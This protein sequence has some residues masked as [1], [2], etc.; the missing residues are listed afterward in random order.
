MNWYILEPKNGRGYLLPG[1]CKAAATQFH[2][3]VKTL[4]KTIQKY[5]EGNV[6]LV[7][8]QPQHAIVP[9]GHPVSQLT[10]DAT[11][12]LY[13]VAQRHIDDQIRC[14]DRRLRR[15]MTNLGFNFCLSTIQRWRKEL[16]GKYKS[17]Y[18]KPS[19]SAEQKEAR[20]DFV[21]DQVEEGG[22]LFQ[23]PRNK[24]HIDE[25]WYYLDRNCV[26]LLVFPGQDIGNSRRVQHKS[27]MTKVMMI[28]AV[29]MPHV[30]PDGTLFDGKIGTWPIVEYVPAVRASKNRPQG[31]IE[32]K[33]VT[34]TSE[35]YLN[36]WTKRG[37]IRDM[38]RQKLPHLKYTG[39]VVQQDGATPHTGHGVA[40]A[41][42]Q[43]IQQGGWNCTLV[44]QPAQSPDLN[45][46]D[47]GL[48]HGMKSNADG[49]KGNGRNI[50]TCIERMELSFQE[51]SSDSISIVWGVLFEVYRLILDD[52]GSNSFKLPHSGVRRRGRLNGSYV[53]RLVGHRG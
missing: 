52:N 27:H 40:H 15:G 45:L 21:M 14:T 49:I 53:D 11:I 1:R 34:L 51:Y 35:L 36:F 26:K 22:L 30:R 19:L 18:I 38:L 29:G 5:K 24:V 43:F 17:T 39:L 47:L 12:A 42:N 32:T 28:T 20:A 41:I 25:T 3:T 2:C 31:T 10:D 37:G 48:F 8:D 4:R 13:E 6:P 44:N 50:D 23:S 46:L 16:K 33:P 9:R 7:E